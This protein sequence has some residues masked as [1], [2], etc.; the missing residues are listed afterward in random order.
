MML[1]K[2]KMISDSKLEKNLIRKAEICCVPPQGFNLGP[3]IKYFI[4]NIDRTSPR[5]GVIVG[6]G[7]AL[8]Y[9]INE[10]KKQGYEFSIHPDLRKN[11]PEMVYRFKSI[12]EIN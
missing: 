3:G 1:N 10:M 9:R 2:I 7:N 5:K 6:S 11:Y 8:I 12:L 4:Y